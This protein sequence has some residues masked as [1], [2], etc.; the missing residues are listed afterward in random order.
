MISR[1]YWKQL[2]PYQK[3]NLLKSVTDLTATL[4]LFILFKLVNNAIEDSD[5]DDWGAQMAAYLTT[6]AFLEQGAFTNPIEFINILNTPSA[7]FNVFDTLKL[8]FSMIY[9][10]DPIEYGVYEDWYHWQK[11]L[12]K[13][14]PLKKCL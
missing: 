7:A 13:I 4:A 6:R 5:D 2:Q 9:D 8:I 10:H 11:G 1:A 14:S 3:R 12:M